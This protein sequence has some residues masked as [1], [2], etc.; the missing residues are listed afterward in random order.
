VFGED[1]RLYSFDLEYADSSPTLNFVVVPAPAWSPSQLYPGKPL[2]LLTGLPVD[3]ATLAND[4]GALAKEKGFLKVTT[5]S[6][7]MRLTIEGIYLKDSLLWLVLKVANHSLI[8]YKTEYVQV[9]IVDKK[10]LKRTAVQE[11]VLDPIAGSPSVAVPGKV[12]QEFALAFQA[13]TLARS[14]KLVIVMTEQNGGR[15]LTLEVSH[16]IVLKARELE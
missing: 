10:K 6:E 4:A 14:K 15:S 9:G 13:F 16:K 12:S 1:G 7:K 8:P 5:H 11:Q 2:L 3:Q